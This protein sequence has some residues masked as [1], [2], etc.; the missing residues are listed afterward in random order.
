[1]AVINGRVFVEVTPGRSSGG[2]LKPIKWPRILVGV[3]DG[4]RLNAAIQGMAV[5]HS[6][7]LHEDA[8]LELSGQVRATVHALRMKADVFGQS[9]L[10]EGS[11]IHGGELEVYL[12]RQSGAYINGNCT[13]VTAEVSGQSTLETH[14]NVSGPYDVRASGMSHVHH[15][16]KI[17]GTVREKATGMARIHLGQERSQGGWRR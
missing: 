9:M 15:T 10:E 13:A 7:V 2:S 14:G 12:S 1:M 4:N 5:L 6:N 3:P 8:Q 16:G 17:I 11:S